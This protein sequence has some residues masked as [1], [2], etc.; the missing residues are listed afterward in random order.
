VRLTV[1]GNRDALRE[2]MSLFEPQTYSF[3]MEGRGYA[4]IGLMPDELSENSMLRLSAELEES[5]GTGTE[6][7]ERNLTHLALF[8]YELNTGKNFVNKTIQLS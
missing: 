4:A 5:V 8:L 7:W 2:Q 3:R 1:R 6:A